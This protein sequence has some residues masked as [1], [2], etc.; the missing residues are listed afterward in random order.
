[1]KKRYVISIVSMLLL[2]LTV[3][4]QTIS[5]DEVTVRA[6]EKQNVSIKLTGGSGCV[7]SGFFVELPEG[8]AMTGDATNDIGTHVMKTNLKNDNVMRVAIYSSQNQSFS[9]TTTSLLSLVVTPDC[10]PGIYQGKISGIEFATNS[11][12]LK[13]MSDVTFNIVVDNAQGDVN[14]DAIVTAG[15]ASLVLQHVASKKTLAGAAKTAA[16]VNGDGQV[17]AGD[18]SLI[19]Q[20]VAGKVDW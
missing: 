13:K 18:A 14:S 10:N 6:K 20:K 19:L 2:G 9:N 8:I 12:G 17:T 16:D 15:D 11:Y 1:M 5:V 3:S 7:A 4:A